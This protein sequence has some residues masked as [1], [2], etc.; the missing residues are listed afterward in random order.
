MNA[1]CPHM[2][3]SGTAAYLSQWLFIPT[4]QDLRPNQISGISFHHQN[5]ESLPV[6]KW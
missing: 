4:Q 1:I 5:P 3:E 6:G 2:A